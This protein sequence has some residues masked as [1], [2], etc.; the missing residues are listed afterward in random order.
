MNAMNLKYVGFVLV[1][2][3]LGVPA[4]GETPMEVLTAYPVQKITREPRLDGKLDDGC[5]KTLPK[6]KTFY[7]FGTLK[8]VPAPFTTTMQIGYSKSGIHIGL[9][10]DVEDM[11]QL[12]ANITSRDDGNI[13]H[14]DS[15][16]LYFDRT[17]TAIGFRKFTINALGTQADLYRMDPANVSTAWSPMGWR[18]AVDIQ[19]AGWAVELFFPWEDLGGPA[20]AGDLWR[21]AAIRFERRPTFTGSTWSLGAMYT[22][23][24]RFG[25]LLFVE[26]ETDPERFAR[27][28]HEKVPGNWLLPVG[29]K[30]VVN[31]RKTWKLMSTRDFLGD[32]RENTTEWIDK[33]RKLA[34]DEK[35]EPDVIRKLTE[36]LEHVPQTVA[37][38]VELQENLHALGRIAAEAEEQYY[39]LRLAEL[40]RTVRGEKD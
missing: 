4:F 36:Q 21:F 6:D 26:Q 25:R 28:L 23:P 30:V 20:Q 12:V 14:D 7:K 10:L 40:Y 13:W 27:I 35:A 34:S 5:W 16:E 38:A 8:A 39:Q 1:S 11:S 31:R 2:A 37:G 9:W 33:A 15:V 17:A 22:A 29:D 18:V 32:I 24:E 19:K 3:W